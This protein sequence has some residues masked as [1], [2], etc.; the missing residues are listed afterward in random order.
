VLVFSIVGQVPQEHF[1]QAA[2]ALSELI[3]QG[4]HRLV[5]ASQCP[6][7]G[8]K[9]FFGS[10]ARRLR[11]GSQAMRRMTPMV[12]GRATVRSLA[13]FLADNLRSGTDTREDLRRFLDRLGGLTA[14]ERE[15]IEARLDAAV[16][17]RNRD[18]AKRF[19]GRP[20]RCRGSRWAARP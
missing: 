18:E 19:R 9:R 12:W 2:E 1:N 4:R 11:K 20:S 3:Q 15:R 5:V 7:P 17:A 6:S 8:R 13:V 14:E 16:I 10:L